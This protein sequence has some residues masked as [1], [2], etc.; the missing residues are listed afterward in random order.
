MNEYYKSGPEIKKKKSKTLKNLIKT[1]T[2]LPDLSKQKHLL[3]FTAT[4]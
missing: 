2:F 3:P 1:S 4:M